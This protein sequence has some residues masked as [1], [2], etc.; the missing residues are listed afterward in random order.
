MG[1]SAR[2]STTR[3]SAVRRSVCG[4][5]SESGWA[6]G[7]LKV[8]GAWGSAHVGA[9]RHLVRHAGECADVRSVES[10]YDGAQ[11]GVRV[12]SARI[13]AREGADDGA[14]VIVA[15]ERA[16]F[17]VGKEGQRERASWGVNARVFPGRRC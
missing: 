8:F 16:R 14:R 7:R 11:V 15:R 9:H 4:S 3:K 2:G 12:L 1:R 13:G 17:S 6:L 10:A 5:S